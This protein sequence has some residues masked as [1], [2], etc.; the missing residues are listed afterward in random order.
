MS[1]RSNV[2]NRIMKTKYKSQ[3]T[4]HSAFTLIELLVVISIIGILAGMAVVSFTSS[5]K[6]ARDTARKSDLSQYRTLLESFA[7]KNSGL[8][9]VY[10]SSTT[11][12]EGPCTTLNTSLEGSGSCPEDPKF[13]SDSTYPRYRYVSNGSGSSGAATAS[14]YVLW[15]KLENVRDMFW[16]VCST[17]QSGKIAS[18]TTIGSGDCPAGLTQ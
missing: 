14:Q 11:A 16:V 3:I 17:G 5:Q 2:S 13:S 12:S 15:S 10:S 7:N 18:S 1:N 4:K 9:P 6:Q 8:Y